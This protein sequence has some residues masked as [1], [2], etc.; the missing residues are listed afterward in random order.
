MNLAAI[1]DGSAGAVPGRVALALE[2][3]SSASYGDLH[4]EVR[5]WAGTL[6][7]HGVGPG[8]RV[9]LADW[10]GVRSIA[11]TLAAA[12]LGAATTQMNPLL[13]APELAQLVEVSGRGPVGVAGS[14]GVDPS[15]A[16]ARLAQ[17]LGPEATVLDRPDAG[18]DV[19][20]A[21]AAGDDDAPAIV[22]FTSGTTGVPKPVSLSHA[23]V[24]E[25][26][27]A[28]RRP[29][30]ADRP[31][32]ITL[33]CVPSFHI[34]GLLGL[35]VSLYGGDTTVVQPRFD[36]GG[37]LALVERHRVASAFVVPT[38]LARILDHPDLERTDTSS[39]RMIS[40]G[41]AA[42]PVALVRRA[43]EQWPAVGFANTF[44]Q[45]ETIG[46][47]TTLSPDDHRDP[48]RIGSVGRPLPGV[49]IRLV[50]PESGPGVRPGVRAGVGPGVGP[51][52][53][54]LPGW[55]RGGRDLGALGAGGA[56]RLRARRLA[57]HRRPGPA[58]RGRL[59]VPPRAPGRHH[60]PGR[61]EVPPVGGGRAP[62]GP[63][64]GGRRG[65]GRRA[66]P[67]T[68]P[69]GGRG[70]RRARRRAHTHPRRA[71]RR[72]AATTWRPSSSRTWSW[73]SSPC[74]STSW[75]SSPGSVA[76]EVITGGAPIGGP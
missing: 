8:A 19:R 62:A 5:R 3:G 60:Q 39:L 10:G 43:M 38:M 9:P 73:W 53:A 64:G 25:R 12:H 32:G 50:D 61:R 48:A 28:Y 7:A 11:V 42:A 51:G 26:V 63:S 4:D 47:Y 46:A 2:D 57:A 71:A 76:V 70:H 52:R 74:R 20:V 33:M 6:A 67:R 1:L 18:A 44:G 41:A 69:A 45:T 59:P 56:A 68:R 15:D 55:R 54:E 13:T 31:P 49:E 16:A 14:G 23:A 29:A 37:W 34:G 40:Y 17:A 24:L 65:G 66:R 36:A 21:G 72:G 30:S 75:A 58:R 27:Q 22:L 35:L